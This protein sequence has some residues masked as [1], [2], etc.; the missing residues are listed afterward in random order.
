M[1]ST[2][3]LEVR[4]SFVKLLTINFGFNCYLDVYY[5]ISCEK[6]YWHYLLSYQLAESLHTRERKKKRAL[7]TEKF[8]NKSSSHLTTGYRQI[9]LY[10]KQ[11]H[12]RDG[13]EE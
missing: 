7:H 12:Y 6:I 9:L 3:Y 10:R 5:V 4:D 8:S 13:K 2:G 1:Q 11:E